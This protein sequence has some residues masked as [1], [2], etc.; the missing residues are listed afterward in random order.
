MLDAFAA[1]LTYQMII[2]H[3][4]ERDATQSLVFFVDILF[5]SWYTGLCSFGLADMYCKQQTIRFN[6]HSTK[7]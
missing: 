3:A 6:D 2:L 1:R 4:V 7:R 5:C